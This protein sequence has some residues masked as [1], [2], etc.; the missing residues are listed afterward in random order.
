MEININKNRYIG[1]GH[2]C[3]IIMDIAANHN[4][5]LK[6]AKKLIEVSAQMGVDAVK[7]QTY[8]AD[9]LY[10]TKTPLFSSSSIPP[11]ELIK[12]YEH[13]RD[14]LPILNDFA[15]EN[16]ID[17]TSSPFDFSA[18]DLLKK[19]N[20]PFY[21]V[22]SP[23]IVDLELIEYMAKTDKPIILSTGMS[24]IGDIEDAVNT[25]LKTNN[26][27]IIILHCNTLYPTPVNIVNLKA[28]K[29]L[30]KVFN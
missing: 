1:D 3:Y 18:V 26:N 27:K 2:P 10:S 25:I 9:K 20:V 17:F 11:Y 21:K 24:N 19:I 16:N 23:E 14:W 8:S 28:I 5:N 4:C 29:T 12:K 13:P 6:T 30:K 15:K 22:A 7:F